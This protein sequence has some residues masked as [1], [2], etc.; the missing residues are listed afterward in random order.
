MDFDGIEL[1]ILTDAL[2]RYF[3]DLPNPV[4][5]ASVYNEMISVTQ[6]MFINVSFGRVGCLRSLIFTGQVH[7]VRHDIYM[8]T[9][10]CEYYFGLLWDAD[11]EFCFFFQHNN[12]KG[13]YYSFF[14]YMI[15]KN[16]DYRHLI[17]F[18]GMH[19]CRIHLI[20][21]VCVHFKNV[22]YNRS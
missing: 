8:I 10:L 9:S 12:V 13:H 6:G 20:E 15:Y 7:C 3:L 22:M 1:H 18:S 21:N 4:I 17:L 11:D 2:K 19:T 5:P 16:W 14:R